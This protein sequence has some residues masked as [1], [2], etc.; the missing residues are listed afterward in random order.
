MELLGVVEEE[1]EEEE[2]EEVACRFESIVGGNA[3]GF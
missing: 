1:E 2:E 3:A